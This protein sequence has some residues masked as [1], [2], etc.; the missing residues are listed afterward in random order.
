MSPAWLA[1]A[2]AVA[3]PPAPTDAHEE[4]AALLQASCAPGEPC[5][6]DALMALERGVDA[7]SAEVGTI[8]ELIDSTNES[9]ALA[10]ARDLQARVR[11]RRLRPGVSPGVGRALE[12]VE[13]VAE[14]DA[15][16]LEREYAARA[17]EIPTLPLGRTAWALTMQIFSTALKYQPEPPGAQSKL[18]LFSGAGAGLKLRYDFVSGNVRHELFGVDVA[19]VINITSV[20]RPGSTDTDTVYSLAPALMLST[21]E[22]FY[23][24]AGVRV[25]STSEHA[26]LGGRLLLFVG[27]GL[28]G[29]T[30]TR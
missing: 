25:A 8:A 29:K 27:L 12:L 15:R 9:A 19:L 5:I 10:R 11:E 3:V 24:G 1:L 21:F 4:L 6:V 7:C 13:A 2:L 17:S 23:F 22:Y 14:A 28:D 20:A 30:L 26:D 16:Y 18:S